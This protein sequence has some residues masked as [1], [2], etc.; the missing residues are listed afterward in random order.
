[1]LFINVL[2]EL[3]PH[4][5]RPVSRHIMLGILLHLRYQ[6]HFLIGQGRIQSCWW[7]SLRYYKL[8]LEFLINEQGSR[9]MP[10]IQHHFTQQLIGCLIL[11]LHFHTFPV[12]MTYVPLRQRRRGRYL[13]LW[14]H[15]FSLRV[16]LLL[17]LALLRHHCEIRIFLR[18]LRGIS[19]HLWVFW[20]IC[21]SNGGLMMVLLVL[22]CGWW[23]RNAKN[24]RCVLSRRRWHQLFLLDR[25]RAI[26]LL[27][28]QF[29]LCALN[30]T[31]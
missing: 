17:L 10:L 7:S 30:F 23:K 11:I 9:L 21:W 12:Y 28:H 16:R 2:N 19:E 31:Y 18:G 20:W 15:H 29:C 14:K 27:V 3:I 8:I 5:C 4:S 24:Y 22:R 6:Q 25:L 13:H 26:F 1:M